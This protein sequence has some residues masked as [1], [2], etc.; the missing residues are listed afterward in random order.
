[1]AVVI[2]ELEQLPPSGDAVQANDH[3]GH[4]GA[5]KPDSPHNLAR[6]EIMAVIRREASR[7]ARLWAD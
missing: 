4:A 1:M 5:Q 6:D 2:S 7:S 3:R